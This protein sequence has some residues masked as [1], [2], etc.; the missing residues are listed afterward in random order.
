MN[1]FMFISGMLFAFL[2]IDVMKKTII[3]RAFNNAEKDMLL[4]SMSLLQYKYHAI[5]LMEIVYDRAAEQNPE[6]VSEKKE[7]VKKIHEKFLLFG[8]IWIEKL[9][10]GLPYET[11]YKNW[12]DAVEY[13]EK[14]LNND[15]KE[16]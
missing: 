14:L 4:I 2:L 16:N 8:N 9:K 10:L 7:V 3:L 12:P 15:R 13:A 5:Q 6:I 1:I 11:K